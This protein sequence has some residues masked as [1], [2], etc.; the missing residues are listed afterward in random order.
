MEPTQEER[1]R[2]GVVHGVIKEV[3]EECLDGE[4]YN[5][6]QCRNLTQMLTDLIKNRVKDMGFHRYKLIVTVTIGQDSNQGIQVVS[7]CLWNKDTDN[8]AEA[9]YVK[10]GLYAVATVYA[11]YFE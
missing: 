10:D 6:T 4:K 5:P 1:F 2:P 11:L 7:R 8:Y 9:H 3:L